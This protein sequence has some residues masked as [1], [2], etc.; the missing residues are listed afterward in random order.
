MGGRGRKS[1]LFPSSGKG[2]KK[3]GGLSLSLFKG[4]INPKRRR[5]KRR[6]GKKRKESRASFLREG[7]EREE[8]E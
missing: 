5:E 2:G 8:N 3:K 7:K 6:K 1:R 4:G